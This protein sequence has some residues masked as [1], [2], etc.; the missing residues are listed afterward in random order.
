MKTKLAACFLLVAFLYLVV[1]V[2]VPRFQPDPFWS[3]T[4][5]VSLDVVIGLSAAWVVGTLLTRRLRDLAAA[6]TV[7]AAGNLTQGVRVEGHDETA[8][9][10]RSFNA[11]VDGLVKVVREV[12]STSR[13]IHESATALSRHSE[14]MNAA[15]LGIAAAAHD[16]AQG[17]ERQAAEIGRT[18]AATRELTASVERV[19]DAARDVHEAAVQA[20]AVTADGAEDSQRAAE[21]MARVQQAVGGAA[22]AVDG[23]QTKADEIGKIVAFITSL[24]QQTHLLAVNAAI[25]AARAGDDARGFA[26]VAEEV[27]RIAENVCGFAEKISTLSDDIHD[28]STEAAQRIREIVGAAEQARER[29]QRAAG[30]FETILDAVR[31]TATKA[32]DITELTSGQRKVAS[33]VDLALERI[34]AIAHENAMGTEETSSATAEQKAS[35]GAM[36][37]SAQSLTRRSNALNEVIAV[38]RLDETPEARA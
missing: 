31:S 16:I 5:I 14:E 7:I 23:F 3:A 38:F 15:T 32:W 17:A 13:A 35:M 24:S 37:L 1:Q 27:R 22:A 2:A 19:A 20:S 25:E 26:V 18:H 21:G 30:S 11:M 6:T 9:L 36:A 12:R 33:E 4:L 29:V 28:G 8:D 10:A 34:S